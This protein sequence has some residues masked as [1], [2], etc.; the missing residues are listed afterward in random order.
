DKD[1]QPLKEFV[2]KGRDGDIRTEKSDYKNY[3]FRVEFKA[4]K[5]GALRFDVRNIIA[6]HSINKS[7]KKAEY[8]AGHWNHLE[9][10]VQRN[11]VWVWLNGVWLWEEDDRLIGAAAS[12]W[13][14]LGTDGD[15]ITFRNPRIKEVK[16]GKGGE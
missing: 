10:R 8:P 1:A 5:T 9:L 11:R 12:G 14:A 16:G 4:A 2:V 7:K 13:V 6:G 15:R 3:V